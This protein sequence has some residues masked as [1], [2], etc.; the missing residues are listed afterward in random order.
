MVLD[1]EERQKRLDEFHK[2]YDENI[3]DEDLMK[4]KTRVIDT[5]SQYFNREMILA[6]VSNKGR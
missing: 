3:L 1:S 2:N 5:L 6:D 4:E